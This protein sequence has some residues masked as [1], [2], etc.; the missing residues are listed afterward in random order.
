MTFEAWVEKLSDMEI[1]EILY[2][3]YLCLLE[4][5]CD[6][7]CGECPECLRKDSAVQFHIES[8]LDYKDKDVAKASYEY[9]EKNAP[10][11][12]TKEIKKKIKSY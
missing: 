3:Y 1:H 5:E 4:E 9:L 6:D 12:I 2:E 10:H 8:I 11:T 7:T